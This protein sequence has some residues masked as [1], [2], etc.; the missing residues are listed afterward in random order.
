MSDISRTDIMTGKINLCGTVHLIMK[1]MRQGFDSRSCT[2]VRST[3]TNNNEG[4]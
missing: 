1:T 2:Q 4:L 3:Y